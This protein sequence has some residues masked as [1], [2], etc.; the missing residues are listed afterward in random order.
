[1]QR[2]LVAGMLCAGK[3]SPAVLSYRQPA[4][5]AVAGSQHTCCVCGVHAN[6]QR[7]RV[8]LAR[9][10]AAPQGHPMVQPSLLEASNGTMLLALRAELVF[11]LPQKRPPPFARDLWAALPRPAALAELVGEPTGAHM[12]CEGCLCTL[13]CDLL[14]LGL[15]FGLASQGMGPWRKPGRQCPLPALKRPPM[16][17]AAAASDDDF[18][19]CCIAT[20]AS[21]MPICVADI[22]RGKVR[23]GHLQES[24]TVYCRRAAAVLAAAAENS[25]QTVRPGCLLHGLSPGSPATPWTDPPLAPGGSRRAASHARPPPLNAR[26]GQPSR[27]RAICN[28]CARRHGRPVAP[29]GLT[30][31]RDCLQ[32]RADR[33]AALPARLTQGSNA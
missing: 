29:G 18:G 27:Q 32:R 28:A 5:P 6:R 8:P 14:L 2:R 15:A 9:P 21:S 13:A 17:L 31:F 7:C 16:P 33:C 22:V 3:P 26:A 30:C 23:H 24:C 19:A 11:E 10:L 25:N 20:S 12:P 1:M 4:Q